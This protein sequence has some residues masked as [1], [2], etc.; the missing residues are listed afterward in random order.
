MKLDE[1]V[2]RKTLDEMNTSDL[3]EQYSL[4]VNGL[5]LLTYDKIREN[6]EQYNQKFGLR[7][8]SEGPDSQCEE[9]HIRDVVRDYKREVMERAGPL[10]MEEEQEFACLKRWK[11]YDDLFHNIFYDNDSQKLVIKKKT[12]SSPSDESNFREFVENEL[13]RV[14]NFFV[15]TRMKDQ[16][17][18]WAGDTQLNLE[19]CGVLELY[20]QNACF[21]I[22]GNGNCQHVNGTIYF[23]RKC[24]KRYRLDGI[25]CV[26]DCGAA[27]L[28]ENGEFCGKEPEN[29]ETA[30]P[31]GLIETPD[32]ANC[33]KPMRKYFASIMNPFNNKP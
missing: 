33:L 14:V 13:V 1:K 18:H 6:F 24:P 17:E 28:A 9:L 32:K 11:L 3:K 4:Y 7:Q 23:R 19:M 8:S 30:C 26:F 21:Q 31:G 5:N 20:S 10:E 16:L 15:P 12:A 27:Q 2:V 29:L 22:F 25:G